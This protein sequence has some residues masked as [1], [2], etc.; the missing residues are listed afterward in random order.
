[1]TLGCCANLSDFYRRIGVD[2]KIRWYDSI[3]FAGPNG[4]RA[5]IRLTGLPAPF[6]LA[7][8]FAGLQHLFD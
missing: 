5:A 2:G 8:S 7:P 1:V 6:H 3:T 4:R